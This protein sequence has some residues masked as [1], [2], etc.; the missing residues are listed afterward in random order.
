M[1]ESEP[2]PNTL[3]QSID[4]SLRL[5]ALEYELVDVFRVCSGESKTSMGHDSERCAFPTRNL[6]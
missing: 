3:R 5:S 1:Y 4:N 2:C 6:H